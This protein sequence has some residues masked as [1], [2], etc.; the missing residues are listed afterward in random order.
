M[1]VEA[2]VRSSEVRN[3]TTYLT[4]ED[5]TGAFEVKVFNI[6]EC[7]ELSRMRRAA[8]EFDNYVRIIGQ[9]NV[10]DSKK[11]M[12]AEDIRLLQSGN[13]LTYHFLEVAYS[14]EKHINRVHNN[15]IF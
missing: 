15:Q 7:T 6:V 5:G 1:K 3:S 13:E 10:L 12:I 11:I 2:A 14:H 9:V 4:V 8:C